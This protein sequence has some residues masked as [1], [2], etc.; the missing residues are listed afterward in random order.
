MRVPQCA[1]WPSASFFLASQRASHECTARQERTCL[2][3]AE[4]GLALE[5]FFQFSASIATPLG[6]VALPLNAA[7][8]ACPCLTLLIQL[9]TEEWKD[10]ARPCNGQA[11]QVH[12][13]CFE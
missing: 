5:A 4:R 13:K 2:S 6:C 3:Q 11:G 1:P 8:D 10:G 12:G 9:V 7:A